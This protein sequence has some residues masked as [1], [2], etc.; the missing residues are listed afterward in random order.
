MGHTSTWWPSELFGQ[1]LENGITWGSCSRCLGCSRRSHGHPKWP[2]QV[3]WPA[4]LQLV[5]SL[6]NFIFCILYLFVTCVPQ[7]LDPR[8]R[9]ATRPVPRCTSDGNITFL[10]WCGITMHNVHIVQCAETL[11]WT[12]SPFALTSPSCMSCLSRHC[13]H[14]HQ[15]IARDRGCL[16]SPGHYYYFEV[17]HG[18]RFDMV[19]QGIQCITMYYKV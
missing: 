2:L 15:A 4:N 10:F 18:L 8:R 6:D 9:N 3:S 13:M 12:R 5:S 16:V 14:C 1:E 19:Q 17:L 7:Q 11:F